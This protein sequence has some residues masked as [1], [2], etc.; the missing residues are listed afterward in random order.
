MTTKFDPVI[1]ADEFLKSVADPSRLTYALG[2]ADAYARAAGDEM[3]SYLIRKIAKCVVMD[4]GGTIQ[5]RLLQELDPGR[6]T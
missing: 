5:H 3:V 6:S 1:Q 2:R 4:K